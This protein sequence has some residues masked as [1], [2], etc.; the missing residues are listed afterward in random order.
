MTTDVPASLEPFL[1]SRQIPQASFPWGREAWQVQ[2]HDLPGVLETINRLP[3]RVDR[4]LI[5]RVVQDELQAGCV[6]CAFVPAM[7]WGWGTTS[8]LGAL[9]TRWIL[10]GV[11]EKRAIEQPVLP[12]VSDRLQAGAQVVRQEG[13]VEAFRFMNNGGHIKHLGSSYFTKWMYFSSALDGPND[14]VAAPILDDTITDWLNEET[15]LKFDR[16]KTASYEAYLD[17]LECWGKTYGLTKVQVE[18]AIFRLATGRG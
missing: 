5:G 6:L 1:S 14:P 7:I 3:D 18:T 10:T 8:G 15:P 11:G 16:A 4:E 9:R 13:P 2:M 12:S 17:L